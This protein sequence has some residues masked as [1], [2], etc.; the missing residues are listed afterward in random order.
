MIVAVTGAEPLLTPVKLPMFP[1][2][3]AASPIPGVLLDHVK[4]VA[5]PLK[6]TLAVA[7]PL[8]TV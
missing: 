3:L 6:V 8:H 2:P 4:L 1:L 7:D 5:V